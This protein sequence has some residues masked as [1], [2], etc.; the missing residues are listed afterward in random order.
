MTKRAP[1]EP[2]VLRRTMLDHTTPERQPFAQRKRLGF[3][4][5]EESYKRDALVYR[6]VNKKAR[7]MLKKWHGF[8]PADPKQLDPDEATTA[9]LL[10]WARKVN[11]HRILTDAI[12][13]TIGYGDA[14]VEKVYL[15]DTAD[16]EQPP[17]VTGPPTSLALVNPA[18]MRPVRD[19]EPGSP[20]LGEVL[21]YEQRV[22]GARSKKG[23]GNAIHYHPSRIEPLQFYNVGDDARGVG[24]IEAAFNAVLSKVK[25]DISLGDLLHW[26]AKGF[27]VL[28]VE[29]ATEEDINEAYKMLKEARE[30][31]INYFAGSERH[32][33]DIKTPGQIDPTGI[34][35]VF[36]IN[37]AAA[38]DMPED[39]LKGVSAGAVTGSQTNLRDYYEDTQAMVETFL[40]P[41]VEQLYA[42]AMSTTREDL[43][44]VVKWN[45][46]YID[47]K[48]EADT[49]FQ[50]AQAASVAYRDG[51][52]TLNEYRQRIGLPVIKGGDTFYAPEPVMPTD[53]GAGGEDDEK[54][55][56]SWRA[57]RRG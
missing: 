47:E 43:P 57:Y 6:G 16:T 40:T 49:A 7:D 29:D 32:K 23:G 21:Y 22:P 19:T 17:N 38:L 28:N 11:L 44:V 50:K 53:D 55:E 4:Q 18:T 14:Y 2:V 15:G 39:M 56:L 48:T 5:I 42:A 41:F 52:M 35:R 36:T 34:Y 33:F 31:G 9:K 30:K 45:P 12:A 24:A 54:G 25:S 51:A 46:L 10:A 20:T 8:A 37:L 27:Y 13:D 3:E 26:D 1:R